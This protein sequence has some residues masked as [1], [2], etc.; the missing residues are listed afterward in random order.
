[1]RASE[2]TLAVIKKF[3]REDY[4]DQDD[5]L[6]DVILPTARSFVISYTGLGT[7]ELDDHEDITIALLVLCS[8]MY[9][10]RRYTVDMSSLNPLAKGILDL[11]CKNYV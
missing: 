8:E 2:I 11:H 6:K 1:M 9:D 10:E 3:C 5:I 4:D 7:D